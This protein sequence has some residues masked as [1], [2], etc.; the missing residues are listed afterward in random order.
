MV[1]GRSRQGGFTYLGLVIFV[2][3]VGMVG[4]ATLKIG[5]LL[6]RAAAEEELLEIGAAFGAALQSYAAATPKGM[7]TY[8]P[9][10]Q[11]LLKDPRFPEV[12]RHLRKIFVDPMTGKAEWGIVYAGGQTGVL[13]IHS[14]S[15]AKPLKIGNFDSRFQG[16]ENKEK[17]SEWRFVAGGQGLLTPGKPAAPGAPKPPPAPPNAPQ[18]AP[19]TPPAAP[20]E[21]PPTDEPPPQQTPPQEPPQET[22][23]EPPD[24]PQEPPQEAQEPQEPPQPPP[25][26]R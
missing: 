12:R 25:V 23:Q 20:P 3:I 18:P 8:P 15:T 17:I 2:A 13:A 14:L 22:P 19:G 9:T 24:E 11:E 7:P 26:R 1:A 21:A 5:S 16:L 4:A 6:Q 10:L